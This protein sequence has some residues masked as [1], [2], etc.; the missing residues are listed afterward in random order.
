ML[1][2]EDLQVGSLYKFINI[3]GVVWKQTTLNSNEPRFQKSKVGVDVPFLILDLCLEDG[4]FPDGNHW[5]KRR[6]INR[7][8]VGVLNNLQQVV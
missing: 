7:G 1:K 2:F 6:M 8:E 5:M 3:K 4:L